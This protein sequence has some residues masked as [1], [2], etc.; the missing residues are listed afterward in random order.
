MFD[1]TFHEFEV[2]NHENKSL[3]HLQ[4]LKRSLDQIE[5]RLQQKLSLLNREYRGSDVLIGVQL[6]RFDLGIN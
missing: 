1:G 6:R 2:D 3:E 4:L 5:W